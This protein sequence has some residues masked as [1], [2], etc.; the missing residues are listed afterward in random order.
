MNDV[1]TSPLRVG[2]V[3]LGRPG[4][5][6]IERFSVSGPF[7]VVATCADPCVAELVAP[8]GVRLVD[9][10]QDL[11]G[12]ADVDVVWFAEHD[13]FRNR[14]TAA[15]AIRAKQT[16]VETPLT[17][18]QTV[19]EH[20]FR[21][22][23]QHR[24]TLLVHN[25]RRCDPDFQKAVSVAQDHSI[26]AIRSAKFVS[27]SYGLSPVS[28]AREH[29]SLPLDA[30]SDTHFTKLRF[31]AHAIDQLMLLVN[32]NPVRVYAI[33]DHT[34]RENAN[35][36]T[37]LSLALQ[38]SF[39]HGCHAEIDIRLDSPTQFQSGWMLTAERGGFANGKRF[40]LTDERE[41]FDSPI[42]RVPIPNND[43][44]QF[45]WL[46]QQIHSGVHD[47]LEEFRVR[48]ATAILDAANQSLEMQ[49]A[50][51]LPPKPEQQSVRHR[52]G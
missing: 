11:L 48:A 10:P 49:Q 34:C 29:C 44:D 12:A 52:V 50:V 14:F 3:G 41:V 7:R 33:G 47:S 27:W 1:S 26:G 40:T 45:D 39:E 43:T 17:L 25:A 21:E 19:A 9:H 4:L 35:L 22:A 2:L 30:S 42:S 36:L 13:A 38:I 31:V 8:F 5:F 24:R 20:I 16:I 15:E 23:A 32:D 46:A 51:D 28:S 6:L 37:G 18:S